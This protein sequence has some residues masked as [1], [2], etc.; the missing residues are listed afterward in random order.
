MTITETIVE[1]PLTAKYHREAIDQIIQCVEDGVYC[2]L[3]GPRL[4]G[5]T[6]LLLYIQRVLSGMG[7][8]CAYV[9]LLPMCAPTL[10]GFFAEMT[11]LVSSSVRKDTG[12][13]LPLPDPAVASSV[14]FR[15][16]LTDSVAALHRD[17]VLIIEHLETVPTDL[18]QSL[19]TSLRAAYMD[20]QNQEF[21]LVVIVSGALS[22]ASLTVGESSPFR[23]ITRRVFVG[24]LSPDESCDM[25]ADFLVEEGIEF[26]PQARQL[27]QEGTSGDTFLIRTLSQQ[28]AESIINRG[29]CRLG[30]RE[31]R[32]VT[33]RFLRRDVY[34]YAPLLE[35]VR[36]IEDDPD[37]MTCILILLE[38]ELVRKTDLPLPLSPDLD[39]LYLTGVV[40][41]VDGDS[42]RLQNLIYRR[43]LQ[44][45]FNPG[46]V[47]YVL[48]M[49]GRWDAAIDYL[50][51]S[52]RQGMADF[53]L[54][55]LPAT[56]NSMYASDNLDKAASYLTRA[57][58]AAFD[59]NEAEVWY[60]PPGEKVLRLIRFM[61]EF[62]DSEFPAVVEIPVQADQLEARAYRQAIPLRGQEDGIWLKRTFP[63][64]VRGSK[65]IG[66]VSL[67][68]RLAEGRAL[69]QRRRDLQ[70]VGFLNQA[71]R[72]LQAVALSRQE[73]AMAG[74]MQVSLL[75]DRV[76]HFEG[77][78][79]AVAWQPARETS[80]DFYDFIPLPGGKVGII[81]ADVAD[82]G[83]GAALYM[84]LSRTYLHN[85]AGDFPEHPFMVMQ[86]TN[87][88]LIRDVGNRNFA[89]IFYGVLDP[90]T[91]VLLYCN[92][93]HN[94]PVLFIGEPADL[95][96]QLVRSGMA[97]GVAEDS[98]WEQNSVQIT[99]GS[100]LLLYTDG[101]TDAHN[102]NNEA[103]GE[104]RLT[105][106]A[107]LQVNDS[108]E[109]ILANVLN[110]VKFHASDSPQ[111]D[112]MTLMVVKRLS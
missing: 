19:L 74:R 94:P 22:L 77:W 92:A 4:C 38:K 110:A 80:G 67:R 12:S 100:V 5:K 29:T 6:V 112:D 11:N 73:L 72:A 25:I 17:L 90:A 20:Q 10:Q 83:M 69:E 91:G 58:S 75:P 23:G 108:A 34:H 61:G 56:I 47:G 8:T 78:D 104:Q 50:E 63:L 106:L 21:R 53:R 26:T 68:D 40:E 41:A 96:N 46:R 15:A 30:A 89:T 33:N 86:E 82:K 55:L 105:N 27:L 62:D 66:V 2:A 44:S 48:A 52:L 60:A 39:P 99:P 71:A 76:P 7:W 88:R 93:G 111:F 31:V 13:E 35:A 85:Y 65:P 43:F 97:L 9:D 45:H 79:F 49:A 16:F 54:D 3:L 59:V 28:S 32:K 81:I 1:A 101:I 107:R 14:A 84:V 36:M 57:L 87:R 37:L 24:D 42:Y 95:S 109:N 98:Q 102:R 51:A 103:F 64:Q 70:L 18:A